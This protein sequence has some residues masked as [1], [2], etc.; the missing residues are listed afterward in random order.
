MSGEKSIFIDST[1]C[2]GCLSCY[3]ACKQWNALPPIKDTVLKMQP[4]PVTSIHP[5]NWI[6]VNKT[7]QTVKSNF[8]FLCL[9]CSDA[10]CVNS[11][12]ESAIF[13]KNGWK[14]IDEKRCI[15]CG[16]CVEACPYDTVKLNYRKDTKRLTYNKAYKCD[17]CMSNYS[18][19]P[20]CSLNCPTEAI[21]FDYRLKVIKLAQEKFKEIKKTN[22]E[23]VLY[24]LDVHKGTNVIILLQNRSELELI[25]GN[26]ISSF[27]HTQK[28]YKLVSFFTGRGKPYSRNLLNV[29]KKIT[30][31]V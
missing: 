25:K 18:K 28:L 4:Q 17:G 27:S 11:C 12:P 20:Q 24:G 9:H 21:F 29:I 5:E 13:D 3:S 7:N 30:E 6:Y 14:V 2:I 1:K 8:P 31:K 23:A 15:G 10:P 22:P 26:R 19:E 16:I